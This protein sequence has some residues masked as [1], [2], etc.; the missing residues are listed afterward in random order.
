[1][2]YKEKRQQRIAKLFPTPVKSGRGLVNSII[3]NLPFQAHIP[4]YKYLGPGTHLDLNLEKSVKPANK[5]DEAALQHDIAYSKS[6]NLDDRHAADYR[7]QEDAWKRVTSPDSSLG[8]KATAWAVTNIMKAKRALGAGVGGKK[9][10][11]QK[12]PQLT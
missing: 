9:K 11:H 10:T 12:N 2:N 8:E 6:N 4:G 3:N 1:M 5:L 7:L